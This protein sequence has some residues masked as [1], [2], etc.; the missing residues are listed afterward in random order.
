[1]ARLYM[2]CNHLRPRKWDIK[3]PAGTQTPT[4]ISLT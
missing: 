3:V 4:F 2:N 1:M